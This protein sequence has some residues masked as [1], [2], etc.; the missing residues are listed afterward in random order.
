MPFST[1]SQG[2]LRV[3]WALLLYL[4]GSCLGFA[5]AP[6][7]D[8]A[9]RVGTPI[10]GAPTFNSHSY[11]SDVVT[12]GVGNSY[13][14]GYFEQ[15]VNF[16]PFP[17][18]T[19][20]A[21]TDLFVA[22]IDAAGNYVWV[23]QGGSSNGNEFG[24]S[25]ARDA[26][27]NLYITGD[28]TGP[29]SVLGTTVLQNATGAGAA[30]ELLVAKLSPSG[31]WLWA[32]TGGGAGGNEG[33]EIALDPRGNPCI[34]GEFV[35]ARLVL[36]TTTLTNAFT[37]QRTDMFAAKLDA[38]GNWLWAVRGGGTGLDSGF[39][40]AVD[41][42]GNVC[43]TG[44]FMSASATFGPYVLTNPGGGGAIYVA[45]LDAAGNWLWA[46][47][48]GG[49]PRYDG[50]YGVA[51]DATGNIVLAGTYQNNGAQFGA[52]ALP[53]SGNIDAFVAKLNAAGTW[54]WAVRGSGS[55]NVL[56]GPVAVDPQG[57]IYVAGAFQGATAQLGSTTLQNSPAIG[58]GGF[59]DLCVG[60][61][62]AAGTWLWAVS[63]GGSEYDGCDG[64]SLDGRGNVYVSGGYSSS[65]L[66]LGPLVL[67]GERDFTNNSGYV[68]RL[69]APPSVTIRGDSLLCNGGS[70]V[71]SAA[72]TAAAIA[73]LWNTGA[74]SPSITITQPGTYSVR[75]T[76]PGG[77]TSTA[78]FVVRSLAPT[79]VI[80]GDTLL[81]AGAAVLLQGL[82]SP[83]A[84]SY[85]WNTGAIT[86]TLSVTQAG[87][88]TL[89]V[90]YG[91]GCTVQATHRLR[92]PS[93]RV[94]GPAVLCQGSA[95]LTA[96]APG[97]T[98][99][100]WSTGATSPTL[101][102]RQ[103][104]TYTVVA[105]FANGCTLMGAV[106]ISEPAV[107]ITGDTLLCPGRSI[108]LTAAFPGA[109][110]YQWSTGATTPAITTSQPGVY[111]VAI[112]Y[113]SG[114]TATAQQAVRAAQ[115][116]PLLTL[117]ADTTLCDQ[118][119]LVLRLPAVG[120]GV[121]PVTYRWSDGSS[122][123][124]L[125]VSHAGLYT[126][127]V[128]TACETRTLSRRVTYQNCFFIP[129]IITPNGDGQNDV[130]T[131]R[132]LPPGAWALTVYNRWGRLVYHAENYR[133][134]WGASAAPGLYYYLLQQP[135]HGSAYKGWVEAA[136]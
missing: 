37:P 1:T 85:R 102:V 136:P 123:P 68:A 117:G 73:Y 98:G 61:L 116:L 44:Y 60:K 131:V 29:T 74:T 91:T 118:N 33:H 28:F 81:C 86:P 19:N 93:L 41:L 82:A 10:V 62:T 120:S 125:R 16:G 128:A 115:A 45:K 13:V 65:S 15:R 57:G 6:T 133:N 56:F 100:R 132:G 70:L 38:A 8:L 20:S 67:P 127:Q 4:G 71:L 26:A 122:A 24:A 88:Y 3:I 54:L 30:S 103:P 78:Q 12:D 59:S 107:R 31:A 47:R 79:L 75:S 113:G 51:F 48:G 64:L 14:T 95:G 119:S 105:T 104:G 63:G 94:T 77:F 126:V 110:A 2:H 112:T 35:G 5:Q 22:K 108:V 106:T 101:T 27:G 114:C 42:A 69:G 39:G 58:V 130:F 25:I 87:T 129:N 124:W 76:F 96:V 90:R 135:G 49:G 84:T 9:V 11:V 72:P 83:A 40:L 53:N 55:G 21:Y 18:A 7:F 134:E 34:T 97:A 46:V 121:G 32:V 80:A 111:R 109:T 66:V 23:V 36:G 43:L 50:G 89:T 52:T 17:L 92:A 99:F